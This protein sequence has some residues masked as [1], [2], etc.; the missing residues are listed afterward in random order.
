MIGFYSFLLFGSVVSQS[1]EA[2][3]ENNLITW[4][5]TLIVPVQKADE[6]YS[7]M[8]RYSGRSINDLGLYYECLGIPSA[9][10]VIFEIQ[11]SP[12]VVIGLCLPKTCTIQDYQRI[13]YGKDTFGLKFWLNKQIEFYHTKNLIDYSNKRRLLNI[14]ITKIVFPNDFTNNTD[15]LSASAIGMIVFL[16]FLFLIAVIATIFEVNHITRG[17]F[18]IFPFYLRRKPKENHA[19]NSDAEDPELTSFVESLEVKK[20]SKIGKVL[21]SF[22]LYSNV[23]KVFNV[24][25]EDKKDCLHNLNVIKVLSIAWVCFGHTEIFRI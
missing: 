17:S 21:W 24:E 7:K 2:E 23:K 13:L 9:N 3:C 11:E 18:N 4:A 8:V 22:S 15:N 14:P 12:A 6:N 5:K 10:Y 19:I 20:L 25:Y 16:V 1:Q